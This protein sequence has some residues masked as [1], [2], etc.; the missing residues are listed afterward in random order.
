M[1]RRDLQSYLAEL[2]R[3]LVEALHAE[4]FQEEPAEHV[5]M[6]LVAANLAAPETLGATVEVVFTRLLPAAGLAG[7]ALVTARLAR[8]LSALATGHARAVRER[9]LAE[10]EAVRR[11]ALVARERIEEALR[12]SE[13]RYR[14]LAHHDILTGL[15]N[16][17]LLTERLVTA[18]AD[19]G[20]EE[21][22]RRIGLCFLDLD[23]FKAV[24]DSLGHQVG[25]A[26]L[27][28]LARRLSERVGA[29]PGGAQPEPGFGGGEHPP[30]NA[31]HLVAR[32][33]GDEFVILIEPSTGTDDV[34][35]VAE[36]AL[37][38]IAMPAIVHG[39]ELSVSASIG[40]VE[41]PIAGTNPT[42]LMRCADAT[43]NWAKSAGRGRWALF[44]TERDSREVAR[45]ALAAAMPAALERGEFYLEY[46]PLVGLSDGV[47]YGVEALLRWRHP[48]LGV[49]P[50]GRFVELAEETGLIVRLGGYVLEQACT[51]ARRWYDADP[52]A[53]YVSVN[54]AVRQVRDAGLVDW[55]SGTLARTG[56]PAH[57]LQLEITE[58]AVMA[59]DDETVKALR[60]LAAMGVRVAIDD[61]GTGYSNLAYLRSL[62][63]HE[64][65]V[66]GSFVEGLRLPEPE[67]SVDAQ[68]MAA[69]VNLA[70]VLG[71]RLTAEGVETAG[72]ARR[73]RAIGCDAGQGWHLG[74]PGPADAALRSAWPGC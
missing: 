57:K 54:L 73:L 28:V 10:Q 47:V 2:A 25:D 71:L 7:G 55:V 6:A 15:P 56:L 33:G 18:F 20:P 31:G 74:R 17:A 60:D 30:H 49:L 45:Y 29:R 11:A 3:R 14:Y 38:T 26:L 48:Q 72:Q 42:E 51:E 24:N 27:T 35:K 70:H 61:F 37:L 43:L 68:I 16:R 62:P 13:A 66:A 22:G 44:E 63:V 1:N 34:V 50:P 53:P 12:T 52:D 64:L 46:Q 40:I 4:P 58:G 65:K 8:L 41:R 5:G 19:A 32:M 9:T 39:H 59:T 21:C 23:G 69:L 36:D 67:G